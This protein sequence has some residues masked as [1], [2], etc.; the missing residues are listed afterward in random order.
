MADYKF[1]WDEL[2]RDAHLKSWKVPS[3]IVSKAN[4]SGKRSPWDDKK[5]ILEA[6]KKYGYYIL[7][8][9]SKVV[10]FKKQKI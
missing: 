4:P 1:N 8:E 7:W 6:A 5:Q 2:F 9:N 10:W 3:L